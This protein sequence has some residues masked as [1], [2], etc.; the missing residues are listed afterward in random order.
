MRGNKN[1]VLAFTY[2]EEGGYGND[3]HDPGGATNLGII[4]V[5]YDKY[6]LAKKLATRSVRYI[7]RSEADEIYTKSYWDKVDGDEL[8]AGIDLVVYD[9]GVNSGPGRAIEYAQ[10]ILGVGVD[11]VMGP[12]TLA[13]IKEI[14]PKTFIVKFDADRLAFLQRLKTYVYFGRGW[15]ARVKRCTNAALAMVNE[16]PKHVQ[17][18]KTEI[19]MLPEIVL[20]IV[21]H[22]IAGSGFGLAGTNGFDTHSPSTW[23]GIAMFIGGAAL[24]IM[25]KIQ[26]SGHSDFLTVVQTTLEVVNEKLDAAATDKNKSV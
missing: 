10:R 21:R 20:G 16:A 8:P 23:F 26:K 24:S 11:G 22:V 13:A 12:I 17:P 19:K 15:S 6:R 1:A 2:K 4:Q 5:E 3:P 18:P 25:D 14:D 7:D 9:Y